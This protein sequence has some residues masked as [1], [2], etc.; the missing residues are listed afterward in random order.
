[1]APPCAE[2]STPRASGGQIECP[3]WQRQG[4]VASRW[5]NRLHAA[6][7]PG[8]FASS[9]VHTAST[10]QSHL[11]RI[12]RH[13]GDELSALAT[14]CTERDWSVGGESGPRLTGFKCRVE[15]GDGTFVLIT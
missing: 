10:P 5:H 12:V 7:A 1:M 9:H 8:W 4:P 3:G 13:I 2:A 14:S 11:P 6:G 15:G